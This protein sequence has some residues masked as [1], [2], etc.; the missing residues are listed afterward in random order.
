MKKIFLTMVLVIGFC[1]F[2]QTKP[3]SITF[4]VKAGLI[5]I[6]SPVNDVIQ[7]GVGY[8]F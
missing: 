7:M 3:S 1:A 8:R 5:T 6:G 2:S 4:G